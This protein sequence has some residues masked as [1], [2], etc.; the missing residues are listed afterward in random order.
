MCGRYAFD[1]PKEIFEVRMLLE[2]IAEIF[3]EQAA[4][5]VKTGEVFPTDTAAVLAQNGGGAQAEPMTWGY[6]LPGTSRPVINARSETLMEK[7]MFH[8]S[9]MSKK[10]LIPCTGFYEWQTFGKQKIKYH[11]RIQDSDFFYLAGLYRTYQLRDMV[12]NR[13]VIITS[14]SAGAMQ[15][16]HHRMPL[17]IP[18]DQKTVWLNAKDN[19]NAIIRTFNDAPVAL[20]IKKAD[21]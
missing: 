15:D 11:I 9:V 2:E 21:G 8:G 12:Y 4:S 13:F 17:M 3:G 7:P 5:S 18:K 20:D 6:L 16:I 10:L 19:I 1:D 14:P